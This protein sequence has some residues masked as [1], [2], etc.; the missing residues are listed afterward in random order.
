M[1]IHNL[2]SEVTPCTL[3]LSLTQLELVNSGFVFHRARSNKVHHSCSKKYQLDYG[4]R[5]REREEAKA[6]GR[7]RDLPVLQS[8]EGQK[9]PL[10][11][12]ANGT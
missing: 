2:H 10:P 6:K 1:L 7:E 12:A 8:D 9:L 11:E 5:K 3:S 4:E